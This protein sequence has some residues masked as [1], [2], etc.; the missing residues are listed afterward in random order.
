MHKR[1]SA[2]ASRHMVVCRAAQEDLGVRNGSEYIT[3]DCTCI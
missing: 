2:Q 1:F 3:V